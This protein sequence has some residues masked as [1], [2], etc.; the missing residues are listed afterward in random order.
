VI[1][2]GRGGAT[3]TVV[4][5]ES[6]REPTGIWFEEQ[7][8]DCVA[9]ALLRFEAKAGD[10]DP[11]ALRRHAQRFDQGRFAEELFG[12]LQSVLQPASAPLP[13]AA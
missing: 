10:F 11:A 13:R 9:D 12:Y 8:A 1:A 2:F 7:S 6:G 5:I 4:P 3:E